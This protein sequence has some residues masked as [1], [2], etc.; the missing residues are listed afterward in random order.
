MVS[1]TVTALYFGREIFVPIA[2]AILLSFILSPPVRLL[3]RL[4]L[5][6]V[7]SA[8][9]VFLSGLVIAFAVGAI[10]ARQVSDLTAEM[11]RYQS[12]VV[13]K[14]ERLRDAALNNPIVE[15]ASQ[16]VNNLRQVAPSDMPGEMQG[17]ERRKTDAGQSAAPVQMLPPLPNV[18][19]IIGTIVGTAISPLAT[20]FIVAVFVIFVLLQREDLRDRFI[21]FVAPRDLHRATLAMDEAAG[22]LSRYFLSQTLINS[23]FGILIALG[24]ALI[25]VPSPILWGILSML[26]RF[27]PYIGSF[28]AAFFPVLLAASV[29]PGWGMA[30]TTL[31]L[32]L[33]TEPIMGQIV[34]PLVYG[35]NTGLSPI[36]VV[37]AATFWTWL[38]GP[39]GLVLATPLTV[40]LVVIGRHVERLE[41]LDILF[42]DAPALSP[43]ESFYERLLMGDPV[44]LVDQ[45]EQFLRE[46]TLLDYYDGIALPALRIAQ[47]DAWRGVLDENRQKRIKDTILEIIEYLSELAEPV[48]ARQEAVGKAVSQSFAQK[49]AALVHLDGKEKEGAAS[50]NL[51][52]SQS[53]Q[54]GEDSPMPVLCIAG[55][56]PLAEAATA[57]FA[58]LLEY[59]GL[60]AA[61]ETVDTLAGAQI[62][63]LAG[64]RFSVACLSFLDIASSLTL[65]RYVTKRLRRLLPDLP[66]IA[67]FWAEPG[68]EPQIQQF[69]GQAKADFCAVNFKVALAI[70]L[71]RVG[72]EEA[73]EGKED[74]PDKARL[75]A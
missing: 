50:E 32:F 5:G 43:E 12:T 40:C 21:R 37:M 38:W 72:R 69:C 66:V 70:C 30:L 26:M 25:G 56:G 16:L 39:I 34:E 14:V 47:E 73:A 10:L 18:W 1:L 6:R 75:P 71:E 36:A 58:H 28:I 42:G 8:W 11:P 15:K 52:L 68:A 55:R 13:G 54:N 7:L 45:A 20:A 64:K 46:H 53:P 57:L 48:S 27:V 24:L 62:G 4:G 2:I 17:P 33:V 61:T 29:D 19:T 49:A 63:R 35:R 9:L 51:A 41:F 44:E 74:V 67:G 31:A 60:R 22:R 3:R 65:A 23:A 59:E